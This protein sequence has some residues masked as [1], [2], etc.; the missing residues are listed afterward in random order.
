MRIGIMTSGGDAPG[1]NAAVR[2]VVRTA[3]HNGIEP[4]GIMRGFL[5]IAGA[6]PD[7][8]VLDT[9][10]VSNI[11]QLGGT[12]LKSGRCAETH[13]PEGRDRAAGHLREAGISVLLAI[14]GNGTMMGLVDMLDHW[15]GGLILLPGTI[16]NDCGGTDYTIGY[17]TALNTAL[18]SIDRIRD[19]AE[20]FDR[21][22]LVEV[23]GR[24]CGA[25]AVGAAIAGGA[26]E[27][28]V[29]ET[30]TDLEALADRLIDRTKIV[31]LCNPN[32][33]TGTFFTRAEFDR[34]LER[35]PGRVL[36]ILDEAYYEFAT[37]LPDFPDS[38]KYRHDQVITL[39]TFSKAYGLAGV[40]IGYGFAHESL[41]RNLHK[42]KLPFEPG[43]PA[44]AAGLGAL[45]DRDFL[46]RTQQ[47]NREGLGYFYGQFDRLGLEYRHSAAN[48]VL[49]ILDSRAQ[50]QTL[51]Q[52]MLRRGVI[53]RPLERF[54]L[55]HC[56]RITVGTAQEN[57]RCVEVLEEVLPGVRN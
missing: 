48:F 29:P 28:I 2:A 45:E 43:I 46:A 42:I 19:T 20:A 3:L 12:I 33:P 52:Q 50:V 7:M 38:M 5:G 41:I 54:G 8:R 31:Y 53:V 49:G 18:D 40:R 56:F 23:M 32:N 11:L 25:L 1:M 13:T 34:F 57:Q 16:D 21:V 4:V 51:Y 14:G 37:D 27:V 6:V 47:M 10:S 36:V 26:E 35:L 15:D 55:P 24:H 22:F 30:A 17:D 9:S 39:R 44:Q